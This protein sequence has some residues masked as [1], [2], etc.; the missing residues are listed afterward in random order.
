MEEVGLLTSS[1]VSFF[2]A[3]NPP[4]LISFP[5]KTGVIFHR[6]ATETELFLQELKNVGSPDFF[7]HRQQLNP[8]PKLF[9]SHST[10][11]LEC[12]GYECLGVLE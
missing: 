7:L 9:L 6:L 8:V 2:S 5:Q 4:L 12:L 3:H 10:F 1:S 11:F